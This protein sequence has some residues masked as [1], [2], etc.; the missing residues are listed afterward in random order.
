[1]LDFIILGLA[2]W[3]LSSL[4]VNEKGPFDMFVA[5]RKL[6][7]IE[8]DKFGDPYMIP[9]N[10]FSGVLSCIWCASLWTGTFWMLVY[11]LLPFWE[12]FAY[13]FALSAIALIVQTYAGKEYN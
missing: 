8:H 7:G 2:T 10:F 11:K 4:L 3:R 12:V 6:A 1:M 9:E 5:I 13:P